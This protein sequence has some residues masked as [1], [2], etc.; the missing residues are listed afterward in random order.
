MPNVV[1]ITRKTFII[2]SMILTTS[3][4][5]TLNAFEGLLLTFHPWSKLTRYLISPVE[6]N[7]YV[8]FPLILYSAAVACFLFFWSREIT[9]IILRLTMYTLA[10]SYTFSFHRGISSLRYSRYLR[11]YLANIKDSFFCGPWNYDELFH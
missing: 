7:F 10:R 5:L 6:I 11:R 9:E 3:C 8:F 4:Y 2:S 1:S